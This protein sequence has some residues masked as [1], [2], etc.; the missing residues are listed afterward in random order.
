M[1]DNKRKCER[2]DHFVVLALAS[3]LEGTYLAKPAK[4]RKTQHW[5]LGIY[6][7]CHY[8]NLSREI[9]WKNLKIENKHSFLFINDEYTYY[10]NIKLRMS[11]HLD[12][13]HSFPKLIHILGF[14]LN[15]EFVCQMLQSFAPLPDFVIFWKLRYMCGILRWALYT[16]LKKQDPWKQLIE[17]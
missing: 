16:S 6:L 9:P 8:A 4:W 11:R 13:N 14:D 10:L 1:N 3:R 7:C 15:G 5:S 12:H 17:F 2:G